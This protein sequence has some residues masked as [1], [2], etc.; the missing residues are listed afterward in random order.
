[1]YSQLAA[2]QLFSDLQ[3]YCERVNQQGT[4]LKQAWSSKEVDQVLEISALGM[5]QKSPG[6]KQKRL[7]EGDT[8]GR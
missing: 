1:M 2:R 4:I 7:E 6:G 8:K 5:C 3:H